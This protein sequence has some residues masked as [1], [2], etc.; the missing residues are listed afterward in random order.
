MEF[1]SSHNCKIN[2]P[3]WEHIKHRQF[4]PI[5]KINP[6][7]WE[8][9]KHSQ[10]I[11]IEK[12]GI[13]K[14]INP[15]QWEHI[16]HC[17]LIPIE[18]INP[19]QW[20]HIK[21]RQLIPIGE[22]NPPQWEH[23]KHR[24]LIPIGEIN[25]PQWEHIKHRQLIPIGEINPPQWEYIKHR[26]L[27]PIGEPADCRYSDKFMIIGNLA[28]E[29]EFDTAQSH[30]VGFAI[31][32]QSHEKMQ[33][34]SLGRPVVNAAK[35]V[36]KTFV[37][38]GAV[39]EGN[40]TILVASENSTDCTF[41]G[42]K[43]WFVYA[44][45]CVEAEGMFVFYFC[46]HG[47]DVGD[48]RALAPSDFDRSE[49]TCITASVLKDW[50][51]EASCK[52]K[53]VLFALDCCY[54]GGVGDALTTDIPLHRS[55]FVMSACTAN[56]TSYT[57]GTLEVS[58]FSYFLADAMR[59]KTSD[60]R[61][62]PLCN[63]MTE[64]LSSCQIDPEITSS[65]GDQ[66]DNDDETNID[67]VPDVGR[68]QYITKLYDITAPRPPLHAKTKQ[69]LKSIVKSI[70]ILRDRELLKDKVLNTAVC[71]ITMS[72][73]SYQLAF[74]RDTVSQPNTFITAFL[75]IASFFDN[76]CHGA[77]ITI[78]HLKYGLE[79]YS[80]VLQDNAVDD[81]TPDGFDAVSVQN[82]GSTY[83][84]VSWD[85]PTHSNGILIN[86]SLYCNGA[87]AGV[88]PLTVISYNTTGLLPFT[89]Y[90]YITLSVGQVLQ[91]CPQ[92]L[93]SSWNVVLGVISAAASLP[94]MR[95]TALLGDPDPESDTNDIVISVFINKI[96]NPDKSFG[97]S[98]STPLNM[99]RPYTVIP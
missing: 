30:L 29:V 23:I 84:I 44:A 97:S 34:K 9:I 79:D 37:E 72:I 18:K 99:P 33:A 86:F 63:I 2:P 68:F 91:S 53:H 39:P 58:M 28:E 76:H 10:L 5:E 81:A 75:K 25:P 90:M 82:V 59:K 51:T 96:I 6:P 47:V 87:L 20:E 31:D 95:R 78:D 12:V 65:G 61:K 55:L 19:P 1:L 17:Q 42:M 93:H 64:C 56:E 60:P 77:D 48:K 46:G 43:R 16:K 3:Q 32:Y 35:L 49:R 69:W 24:Q 11:P 27:I 66:K 71:F 88:L 74:Q 38:I 92:A 15:P 73:A 13:Y 89:L 50:L 94:S 98:V 57:I 70:T 52:A 54:A 8:H 4:I 41:E 85:L 40:T 21:H 45:N 7:Q 26:Q 80:L 67:G 22:I 14:N 83:I 62:L 36:S